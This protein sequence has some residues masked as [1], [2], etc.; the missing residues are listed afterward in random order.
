MEIDPFGPVDYDAATLDALSPEATQA[1]DGWSEAA[2]WGWVDSVAWVARRDAEIMRIIRGFRFELATRSA[3]AEVASCEIEKM[4][5]SIAIARVGAAEWNHAERLLRQRLRDG[6]LTGVGPD[7]ELATAAHWTP[8]AGNMDHL[9]GTPTPQAR[10]R[11]EELRRVWPDRD[12]ASPAGGD[13]VRTGDPGRPSLGAELYLA[14]F[15]RR[16]ES[17][18][19]E[20][21]L[22]DE[23]RALLKWFKQSYPHRQPPTLKTITNRIRPLYRQRPKITAK[24]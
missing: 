14:E 23:V 10:L 22:A 13:E 16:C 15:D 2:L 20:L 4:L 11:V 18:E 24:G 7:G 12:D 19:V 3:A 17:G 5:R 9:L 21:I 8:Q 6:V 1:T